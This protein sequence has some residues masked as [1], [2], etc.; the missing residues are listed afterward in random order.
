MTPTSQPPAAHMTSLPQ[1][2]SPAKVSTLCERGSPSPTRDRVERP[3]LTR[4]APAEVRSTSGQSKQAS[5]SPQVP[6]SCPSL[7]CRY[8]CLLQLFFRESCSG[9]AWKLLLSL[10][11]FR[12]LPLPRCVQTNTLA[13]SEKIQGEGITTAKLHP[14]VSP[15]HF[16]PCLLADQ[17]DFMPPPFVEGLP[18]TA[19]TWLRAE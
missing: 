10:C 14:W 3:A 2:Q 1:P 16:T 5:Q 9:R 15:T 13:I 19:C 7:A 6:S 17:A 11:P 18:T 4:S 12:K 8:G